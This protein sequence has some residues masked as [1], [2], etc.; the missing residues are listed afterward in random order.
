[1]GSIYYHQF[2]NAS[3]T[4]ANGDYDL[5]YVAPA[6]NNPIRIWELE[7]YVISEL[8]DAA[9]EWLR[10]SLIRGHTT[11]GSGGNAITASGVSRSKATDPTPSATLRTLDTTIASAGT[12]QNL[13]PGAMNVRAGVDKVWLPET[14]PWCTAA[15]TSIVVRLMAAVTDD[16]T[17]NG[18]L[19]YE[20][21]G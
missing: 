9:E 8:G 18:V 11:V 19:T 15:Q 6:T 20:E 4:N 2:E 16:V 13:W 12:T 3:V 10:I 21:I 5:F 1:M 7:L 14:T 17:M